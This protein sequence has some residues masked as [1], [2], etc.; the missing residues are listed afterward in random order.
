MKMNLGPNAP[1][2]IVSAVVSDLNT[3]CALSTD[4]EKQITR[5]DMLSE[6]Y[7][8]NLWSRVLS[9]KRYNFYGFQTWRVLPETDRDFYFLSR[10]PLQDLASSAVEAEISRMIERQGRASDGEVYVASLSYTNPLEAVLNLI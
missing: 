3:I 9:D 10:G 1:I 2:Q 4:L 8:E 6:F 5:A 7:A